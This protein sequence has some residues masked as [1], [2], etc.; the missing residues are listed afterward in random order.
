MQFLL[1]ET[2][3]VSNEMQNDQGR[4]PAVFLTSSNQNYNPK[5]DLSNFKVHTENQIS[6]ATIALAQGHCSR[7]LLQSLLPKMLWL[8][9]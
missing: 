6:L 7:E 2:Y 5:V 3:Q 8:V 9:P 1:T 4:A